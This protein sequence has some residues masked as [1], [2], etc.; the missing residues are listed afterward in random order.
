MKNCLFVLFILCLNSWAEV[1]SFGIEEGTPSI[2]D[3]YEVLFAVVGSE[4]SEEDALILEYIAKSALLVALESSHNVNEALGLQYLPYNEQRVVAFTS[5]LAGLYLTNKGLKWAKKG[6]NFVGLSREYRRYKDIIYRMQ[7][8]NA[9]IDKLS[10]SMEKQEQRQHNRHLKLERQMRRLESVDPE[11]TAENTTSR[12]RRIIPFIGSRSVVPE[13]PNKTITQLNVS[14]ATIT[15]LL[16][17]GINTYR[18]L[19]LMTK[20]ELADIPQLDAKKI[21]TI[22][23]AFAEEGYELTEETASRGAGSFVES[24]KL[25]QLNNHKEYLNQLKR[26]FQMSLVTSKPTGFSRVVRGLLRSAGLTA[27][28][29]AGVIAYGTIFTDTFVILVDGAEGLERIT[30]RYRQ[31]VHELSSILNL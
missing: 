7:N 1:Q 5:G 22:V 23:A 21:N 15:D 24:E 25:T 17:G 31:D 3:Q 6:V 29:I 18:D 16:H 12:W 2:S 19:G 26:E 20:V 4:P 27:V 28:G 30:D 8:L 10:R 11:A 13:I 9:Q 14:Q